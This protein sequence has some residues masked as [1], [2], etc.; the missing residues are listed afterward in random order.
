MNIGT[1]CF[2]ARLIATVAVAGK[3]SPGASMWTG[4]SPLVKFPTPR[5]GHNQQLELARASAV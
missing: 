3:V 5:H 4:A 2:H 1:R